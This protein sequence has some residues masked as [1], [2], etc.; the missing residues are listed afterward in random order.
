M[1]TK[2]LIADQHTIVREAIGK[3]IEKRKDLLVVGGAADGQQAIL[4]AKQ[5]KPRCGR[6]AQPMASDHY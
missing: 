4:L 6:V 2:I 3:L 5:L 1:E